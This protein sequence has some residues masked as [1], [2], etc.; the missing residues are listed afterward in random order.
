MFGL[1]VLPSEFSLPP[2]LKEGSSRVVGSERDAFRLGT[3]LGP[4]VGTRVLY[5]SASR[6]AACVSLLVNSTCPSAHSYSKQVGTVS[7]QHGSNRREFVCPAA[8]SYC[9]A[10]S[11]MRYRSYTGSLLGLPG[12]RRLKREPP[13]PA[14]PCG[15]S[16]SMPGW[17][18]EGHAMGSATGTWSDTALSCSF[19][20]LPSHT[21]ALAP[22]C[23]TTK[24]CRGTRSERG[25]G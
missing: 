1:V 6:L 11:S 25:V 9:A 15:D 10:T 21:C 4:H 2:T 3:E 17:R 7:M 20:S 19:K 8:C 24:S 14:E 16:S 23:C 22:I 5:L 18:S 13:N 12:L